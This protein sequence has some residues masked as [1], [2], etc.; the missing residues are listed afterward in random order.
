MQQI[1]GVKFKGSGKSYY[2]NPAGIA[3]SVEDGVIA[4]T[5]RGV[6][7][8]VV[9]IE[10]SMVE[11]NEIVAPLKPIIRKAN[12]SDIA[13]L[14]SLDEKKKEYLELCTKLAAEKG[15]VMKL[16]NIELTFDMKKAVVYYTADGRVD[17]RELVKEL[18]GKL[19]ARI[20]MRQIYEREDIK[21][22][23]ALAGCGRPCC[24][25]LFLSDFERVSLKM[26]KVQGL[27]LNPN[28]INGVCGKLMCCLKYE[29][30]QYQKA[31]R[32]MPAL[33][34]EVKTPDGIGTI[35]SQDLLQEKCKVRVVIDDIVCVNSYPLEE[36][37]FK[38]GCSNNCPACTESDDDD[39]DEI[40]ANMKEE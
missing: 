38:K 24:C 11:D 10:N 31:S 36:L 30:E 39:I 32:K 15:L 20:E 2:F 6:E 17:F 29:N 18:A 26:A 4:E 19:K 33:N 7:Y 34:S 14:E 8:G 3:F 22:R 13:R 25:S 5:A 28:K 16:V 23:G 12:G 9:T 27:S 21:M 1:I 40:P 37:I 35:V